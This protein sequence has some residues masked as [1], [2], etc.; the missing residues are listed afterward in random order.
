MESNSAKRK[1][2]MGNNE[3]FINVYNQSQTTT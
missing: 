3:N 2:G 1:S